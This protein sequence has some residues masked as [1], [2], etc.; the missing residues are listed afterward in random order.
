MKGAI[1]ALVVCA[2]YKVALRRFLGALR[3]NAYAEGFVGKADAGGQPSKV[4]VSV[5]P[6]C[7]WVVNLMPGGTSVLQTEVVKAAVVAVCGVADLISHALVNLPIPDKPAGARFGCRQSLAAGC[8]KCDAKGFNPRVFFGKGII[9]G[10]HGRRVGALE[11]YNSFKAGCTIACEVKY[12]HSD[13]KRYAFSYNERYLRQ[14]YGRCDGVF[15][16][17]GQRAVVVYPPL[18]C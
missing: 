5:K 8:V 16:R 18:L 15:W 6:Q 13:V 10:K 4:I 2:A 1:G 12:L 14:G 17:N 11:D 9:P 3:P 7:V